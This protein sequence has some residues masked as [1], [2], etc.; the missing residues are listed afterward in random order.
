[1]LYLDRKDFLVVM[2]IHQRGTVDHKQVYPRE[3]VRKALDLGA[4]ETVII[5]NRPSDT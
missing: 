1:M 3:V 5:H 2:K 4:F